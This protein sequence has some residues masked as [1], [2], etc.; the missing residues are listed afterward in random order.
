MIVYG[1]LYAAAV[2][3]PVLLGSWLLAAVLRRYGQAERLVWLAGLLLAFALPALGMLRGGSSAVTSGAGEAIGRATGV[4]GLPT[5]L[6]VAE[7]TTGSGLQATLMALWVALSALLALRYLFA[8]LRLAHAGRSWKPGLIDGTSV[9]LT[10][11]IGP[12]VAGLVRP[13]VLVPSWLA[14]MSVDRRSLVLLH[15]Q[16]HIR[17]GDPW[18]MLLSRLAP[19][20]VPWNPI[21]WALSARL[22]RA[23]ELDCDRRVLR[24]RPDVRAYGNTLIELS[25]RDSSRLVAVAAFAESEAPL[26]RRILNMTTPSRAVSVVALLS[27]TVFGVVLMVAAFQIPVPAV[28]DGLEMGRQA[29]VEFEPM[30]VDLV[31]A[32]EAAQPARPRQTT[33][34]RTD[35]RA[36]ETAPRYDNVRILGAAV[37]ARDPPIL[38]PPPPGDEAASRQYEIERASRAE[39]PLSAE[40]TFTP[41]TA[42]PRLQNVQEVKD[43]L[44][45]E[46]P[47]VLRDSGIGGS[48]TVWFFI[49]ETGSVQ[50][51]RIDRTSGYPALD[52]AAL[53]IA[54]VY[55]FSPALNREQ[56][57]PVWVSLPITFEVR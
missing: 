41:F 10:Q 5:V 12:A 21:V 6:V 42:P 19:I 31:P 14:S 50:S 23:I 24:R 11:G 55:R 8:A 27:A 3:V 20:A 18:L 49:D 17:A 43:A 36:E 16:E 26:R 35:P 29:D 51:T 30:Q 25:S 9:W 33:E 37:E 13:R 57:V 34:R 45:R 38:I 44:V 39:T 32:P 54:D 1:M 56:R 47:T 53:N 48:V 22:L 52:E 4:I 7:G 28:A 15:E 2:G 40:P 46:Y